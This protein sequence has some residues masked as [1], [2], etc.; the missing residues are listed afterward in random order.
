MP[1][2][3]CPEATSA[4]W[5][6]STAIRSGI[7]SITCG[8]LLLCGYAVDADMK[9]KIETTIIIVLPAIGAIWTGYVQIKQRIE[10]NRCKREISR[11]LL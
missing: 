9:V 3:E 11:K 2:T 10:N 1:V 7:V 6:E 8:I 5:W 4:K